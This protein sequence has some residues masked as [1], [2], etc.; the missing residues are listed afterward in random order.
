MPI[1][2]LERHYHG[3]KLCGPACPKDQF[4][5]GMGALHSCVQV[6]APSDP[7][8]FRCDHRLVSD[9]RITAGASELV[10]TRLGKAKRRGRHRG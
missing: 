4:C 5:R 8:E 6:S 9:S 1:G 2:A 7:L 10:I 3:G